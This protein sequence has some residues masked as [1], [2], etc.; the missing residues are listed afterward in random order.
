MNN[1]GLR[2]LQ[3]AALSSA[4][5]LGSAA[6]SAQSLGGGG[7]GSDEWTTETVKASDP[8]GKIDIIGA[9]TT[10]MSVANWV[11]SRS[12][13]EKAELTGRCNVINHPANAALYEPNT[14]NFCRNYVAAQYTKR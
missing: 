5:A 14:R 10:A 4:I 1:P 13:S 3:V 11:S 7:T 2:L 8:F 12:P 6:A 9:G